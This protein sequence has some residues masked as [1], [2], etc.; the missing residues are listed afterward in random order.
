MKATEAR[1]LWLAELRT[2]G[3]S[4][5]TVRNY[6]PAT[7]EAERLVAARRGIAT[8]ALELAGIER[9]DVVA[10]LDGYTTYTTRSGS[11][12]TRAR[13]TQLSFYTALRSFLSWCVEADKLTRNPMAT[14]KQPTLPTLVP[15]AMSED[16]CRQLLAQA[17]TSRTPERDTL[18]VTMALTMGLRLAEMAGVAPGDFRRSIE[19]PTHLRV[20]GK[21]DKER[22]L[23][24]PQV[25][26]DALAAYLP[27][28]AER[29]ARFGASA[30]TLLLTQRPVSSDL[31]AGRDTVSQIFDRL[32]R[33]GG[34]KQPGRRVHAARHSFATHVLASGADILSV[35]ELLGHASV[36]TTQIYLKVDPARLASAVEA[37]PLARTAPVEPRSAP[38]EQAE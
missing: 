27:V 12:A 21:G 26:R 14:I 8:G 2:A 7:D 13:S 5:Y 4:G 32:L 9:D 25:V 34:L 37:N 38:E 24:V 15:K 23:P 33:A 36:S 28:R 3:A 31:S 30:S 10:A 18:A 29:L 17:T 6:T 16:E 20:V 1:N 11:T 35:S 22:V 19:E